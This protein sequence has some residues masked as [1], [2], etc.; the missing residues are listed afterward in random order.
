MDKNFK[1]TNMW[2]WLNIPIAI[3]LVIATG[4]GLFINGIYRDNPNFVSQARGQDFISLV[5]LLPVL[6]IT[7]HLTKRESVQGRLIWLGVLTYLI[8]TYAVAAF[9]NNFNPLFLVYVALLGCS[10]YALIGGLATTDLEGIKVS[11]SKATPVKVISVYLAIL[12]LLFYFL[13]LSEDIPALVA[14]QIPQSIQDNGTPTN[15]VHVLDMMWILPAFG[16]AAFSLWHKQALGYTLT[17]ALLSYGVLLMLA[18]LSMVV[19][20]IQ[21]AQPVVLPQVVIFVILLVINFGML[22]K[23]LKC[24]KAEPAV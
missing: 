10:L 19:F 12:M 7:A 20:M 15:P 16:I 4:G 24:V 5:V 1:Q 6:I 3:L 21:E 11:F 22:T 18:I 14:G 9:D 23:Y 2:L 13:W 8:Y 17:G